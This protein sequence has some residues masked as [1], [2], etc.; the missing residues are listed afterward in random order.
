MEPNLHGHGHHSGG[1]H[2]HNGSQHHHHH[3]HGHHQRNGS[4][5]SAGGSGG[6][7]NST[8]PTRL[9]T[10]KGQGFSPDLSVWFGT[11]R[12]PVTELQSGEI[13]VAHVPE[14]VSL[15]SSFYFTKDD[16]EDDAEDDD[17]DESRSS[18]LVGGGS[19]GSGS[20]GGSPATTSTT[21]ATG[22]QHDRFRRKRVKGQFESDRVPILLV[23]KDG[24][25]YR[26]GHSINLG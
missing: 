16:D 9:M 3:S 14:E 5:A 13:L 20:N 23:R 12:A 18:V 24:V 6:L 25:V 10:L 22:D 17:D 7:F 8:L 21:A 19:D 1:H 11:V 15:G 4:N 26:S 2:D